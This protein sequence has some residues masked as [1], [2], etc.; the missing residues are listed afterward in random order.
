[1]GL[2]VLRE[3]EIKGERQNI[4][5][6]VVRMSYPTRLGINDSTF[7]VDFPGYFDQLGFGY[8]EL[9]SLWNN[10][11]TSSVRSLYTPEIWERHLESAR[12]AFD[13]S[14][15]NQQLYDN[16][17]RDTSPNNPITFQHVSDIN[18]TYSFLPF[19]T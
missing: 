7:I 11:I 17:L 5:G 13:A 10:Y 4:V 2:C 15:N 3:F 6:K 9:V 16:I 8:A 18:L 12:E 19:L 1:V 14:R